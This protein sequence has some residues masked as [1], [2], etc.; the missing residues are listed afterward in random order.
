MSNNENK[1]GLLEQIIF[2]SA[3]SWLAGKPVPLKIEGTKKQLDAVI[4]AF[5]TSRDFINELHD[6]AATSETVMSH[7]QKKRAAAEDF[8]KQLGISWLL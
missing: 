7:L 5:N 4:T 6:P 1:E 3:M 8:E 2:A